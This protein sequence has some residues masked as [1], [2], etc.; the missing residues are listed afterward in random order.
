MSKEVG[1]KIAH[2]LI[3]GHESTW[4]RRWKGTTVHKNKLGYV[5]RE[6]D[7]QFVDRNNHSHLCSHICSH[8]T[9]NQGKRDA[10]A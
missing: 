4:K 1:K 10:G 6:N 3:I 9:I 8:A 7:K 5:M 2:L